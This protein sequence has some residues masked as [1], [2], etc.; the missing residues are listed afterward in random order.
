[1]APRGRLR[2]RHGT[3]GTAPGTCPGARPPAVTS[4]PRSE[5]PR[6]LALGGGDSSGGVAGAAG[7]QADVRAVRGPAGGPGRGAADGRAVSSS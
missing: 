7:H 5:D 3:D 2:G 6:Q 4:T 1:M